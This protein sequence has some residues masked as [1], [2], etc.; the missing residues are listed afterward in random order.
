MSNHFIPTCRQAS[1]A[2]YCATC[3]YPLPLDRYNQTKCEEDKYVRHILSELANF[4][5]EGSPLLGQLYMNPVCF[6]QRCNFALYFIQPFHCPH[7][8]WS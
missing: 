8:P 6:V 7:S 1:I 3:K 2:N 5:L 4:S